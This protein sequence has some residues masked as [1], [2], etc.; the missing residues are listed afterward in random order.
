MVTEHS[1]SSSGK[2]LLIVLLPLFMAACTATPEATTRPGANLGLRSATLIA[3]AGRGSIESINGLAVEHDFTRAYTTHWSSSGDDRLARLAAYS[4]ADG[5]Q[6][7]STLFA[8]DDYQDYQPTLSPD[9]KL[10]FFT[11]T[12]PVD[13]TD[14]AARQN[15]WFARRLHDGSWSGPKPITTLVSP[16][17]DGHAMLTRTG[18]LYF[19]SER[20]G[21]SG[22]VDI[23]RARWQGGRASGIENVPALNS[24]HSDQDFYLDPDERYIVLTRY[25]AE[26]HDL[27]LFYSVRVDGEWTRPVPFKSLNTAAWELSPF[28]EQQSGSLFF[29]RAD[30]AGFLVV[31]RRA[32]PQALQ[33]AMRPAAPT[34]PE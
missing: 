4:L 16:A 12:R 20:S 24:E 11:S 30:T 28:I 34:R 3:A 7:A 13:G 1:A 33:V 10:L 15:C 26:Q 5:Y 9:G 18:W 31:E 21:G 17:W 29:K 2:R 32:L 22:A 25:N 14:N 19:A 6:S 23:Y 8:A 27:D